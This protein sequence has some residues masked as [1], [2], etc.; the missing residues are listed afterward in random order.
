MGE[1][2]EQT[3]GATISDDLLDEALGDEEVAVPGVITD[4]ETE[5][6]DPDEEEYE[7]DIDDL[8]DRFEE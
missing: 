7:A 5:E 4:E 6:E 1:E 8:S 3:F 2:D